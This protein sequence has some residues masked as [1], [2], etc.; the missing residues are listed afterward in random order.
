MTL[1]CLQLDP[2]RF[3][4]ILHLPIRAIRILTDPVVDSI[5]YLVFHFV[6]PSIF[7]IGRRLFNLFFL[8]SLFFIGKVF[9]SNVSNRILESTAL[10]VSRC[11]IIG[12]TIEKYSNSHRVSKCRDS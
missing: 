1:F 4:Q 5:V 9:G 3:L 8:S 7:R 6:F 12:Y 10:L 11:K 2:H